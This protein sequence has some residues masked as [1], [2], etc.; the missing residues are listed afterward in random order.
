M[1]IG[2]T[3]TQLV[4]YGAAKRVAAGPLVS[5]GQTRETWATGTANLAI[6][7]SA[8]R[9]AANLSILTLM[10][11]AGLAGTSPSVRRSRF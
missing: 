1:G 3:Q 11:A 9:Y 7:A 8:A 5:V 10:H 2:G 6:A 4:R